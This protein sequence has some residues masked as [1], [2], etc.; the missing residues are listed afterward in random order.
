MACTP[1]QVKHTRRN[2]QAPK[3][4]SMDRARIHN[5]YYVNFGA[6]QS[7]RPCSI[8]I[9]KTPFFL[10]QSAPSGIFHRKHNA[11]IH[12]YGQIRCSYLWWWS[13]LCSTWSPYLVVVSKSCLPRHRWA[14]KW[15]QR[16]SGMLRHTGASWSVCVCVWGCMFVCV[17]ACVRVCVCVC[18]CVC[19]WNG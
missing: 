8:H 1:Q 6:C 11:Y 19:V 16:T 3:F 15:A 17:C 7:W 14:T 5:S 18:E 10:A 13:A 12:T 9:F 4:T 2:W